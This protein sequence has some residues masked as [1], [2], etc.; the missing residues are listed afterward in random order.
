MSAPS[1]DD[2]VQVSEDRKTVWVHGPDGS[3]VGR[4]SKVFGMDVHTT[5]SEQLEGAGQ[6]LHC[7]HERPDRAEWD[8]FCGLMLK[9]Y[10]IQVEPTALSFEEPL[11]RAHA[12]GHRGPR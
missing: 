9:H 7:T 5:L 8:M 4:F 6:C 2:I 12:S 11:G 1:Y 10:G 3:T